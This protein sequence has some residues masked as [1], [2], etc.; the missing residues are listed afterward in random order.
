MC[1]RVAVM[2]AGRIAGILSRQELNR[3]TLGRLMVG[4][5]L[6]NGSL[7]TG[8]PQPENLAKEAK[9]VP[10]APRNL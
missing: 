8:N 2:Y 3:E 6:E 1:D 5:T 7:A 4:Q 9:E 10:D